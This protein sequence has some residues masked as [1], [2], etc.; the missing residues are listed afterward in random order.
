[1]VIKVQVILE[2]GMRLILK[3][4]PHINTASNTIFVTAIGDQNI[5]ALDTAG[6]EHA[7]TSEVILEKYE[8]NGWAAWHNIYKKDPS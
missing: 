8:M 6:K 4:K 3:E 5:L 7:Y 1:M 2:V